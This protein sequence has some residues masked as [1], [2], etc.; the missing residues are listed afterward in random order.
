MILKEETKQRILSWMEGPFDA[1]T[2]DEIAR[3][4]IENPTE[5]NNAF[6]KNSVSLAEGASVPG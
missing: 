1:K 5:L 6:F 3:L 4:Q 2:K